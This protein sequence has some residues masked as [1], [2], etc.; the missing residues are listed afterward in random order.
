M[1][2]YS[3]SLFF[4]GST[5]KGKVDIAGAI[6]A[7]AGLVIA[8]YAIV[9]AESAGWSSMQTLGLLGISLLLFTIFY[10]IQKKKK[11][12]LVPLSIF[13]VPNLSPGNLVMALLAASWIPLWFFLNL[14]L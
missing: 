3:R 7:T 4:K 9:S 1:L 5:Q 10:V 13:K 14:Y 8:V 2:F 12:P 11:E 6:F